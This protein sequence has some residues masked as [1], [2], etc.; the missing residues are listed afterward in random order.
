VN[1]NLKICVAYLILISWLKAGLAEGYAELL[2]SF[3][4]AVILCNQL[5]Q[6]FFWTR[7]Y[8]LSILPMF[9]ITI[10]FAVAFNNP[11]YR[12]LTTQDLIDFKMEKTLLES[13]NPEKIKMIST[14]I[15]SVLDQAK[16]NP[17]LSI[18][19]FFHL[20]SSYVDK[21][22][23]K[24]D[25][26]I[27]LLLN[28]YRNHIKLEHIGFLPSITTQS[29]HYFKDLFFII[30]S[31][32]LGINIFYNAK[33]YSTI[34][35]IVW[36]IIVNTFLLSLVG[37]YQRYNQI[38]S[39]DFVEI[40]GIWN[41]PEPRY[42]FSTFTYKNHWSAFVIISLTCALSIIYYN[43]KR[44]TISLIKSPIKIFLLLIILTFSTTIIY[45]GSR[46]GLFLIILTL[47]SIA[48]IILKKKSFKISYNLRKWFLY[49]IIILP[50]LFIIFYSFVKD[51]KVKEMVTNSSAQWNALIDGKPP[52]RF[53]LWQDAIKMIRQKNILG[54][55]FY[56]FPSIYPKY[57]SSY[58]RSERSIGL[59]NAHNPYV[60][61]VAHA[62]NDIL[63]FLCEW[64]L[65]GVFLFFIPYLFYLIQTFCFSKSTSVQILLTGCLI[66]LVY[67]LVDFP[68]RTPACFS[69]FCI[70]AGLA[71]KY[72][73]IRETT[74]PRI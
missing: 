64:G 67:C 4:G 40:L 74:S 61:L 18:A 73:V 22:S 39:D 14:G 57:Q 72:S 46:S 17:P 51:Q 53:L 36:I 49:L 30:V 9:L 27:M 16:A 10:W 65:L 32:T 11:R 3:L 12:V 31:I 50:I 13:R 29:T 1:T 35:K 54:Y 25:D 38:W 70:V 19:L 43:T 41:A 48:L 28:S 5:F 47:L 55:G 23:E 44:N 26:P 2:L 69:L 8:L 33:S 42:Y 60:P 21:Y 20:K 62:H 7:K 56:A 52:L 71:C 37:I 58:V 68:T 15:N 6:K 45:S 59:D 24:K 34:R 66:F 63:E